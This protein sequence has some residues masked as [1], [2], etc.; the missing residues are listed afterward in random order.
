MVQEFI[1]REHQLP[2]DARSAA[3]VNSA[4]NAQLESLAT[5]PRGEPPKA[6]DVRATYDSRPV[7][8]FDYN[9]PDDI[10]IAL[11]SEG[12]VSVDLTFIVPTGY[13]AVQRRFRHW[14]NPAPAIT[15]RQQCTVTFL[16]SGA[17][18]P[19]NELIPIGL[20]NDELADGFF[21]ADEKQTLTARVTVAAGVA[22]VTQLYCVFYGNL[23][24]K[25]GVPSPFEIANPTDKIWTPS[26]LQINAPAMPLPSEVRVRREQIA[27]VTAPV[28]QHSLVTSA[29]APPAKRALHSASAGK[30]PMYDS[31]TGKIVGYR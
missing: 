13:I 16:V 4:G 8:G 11:S 26:G 21:I 14:F 6:F 1:D 17:T 24:L 22:L 12:A 28:L 25:T 29:P 18:V 7:Q 5:T 3:G 15:S 20:T 2:A 23:I 31:R 9:I 30:R 19:Y 10:A 27:P